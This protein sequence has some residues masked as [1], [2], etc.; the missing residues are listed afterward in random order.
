MD[1]LYLVGPNSKCDYFDLKCSLRSIDMYG[2]NVDRVFVCGYCPEFLS[3]EVIKLPLSV[4]KSLPKNKNIWRQIVHCVKNSD[5]GVYN[6]GD[7]LI[8]MDDHFYMNEVDFNKYPVLAKLSGEVHGGMLPQ[9]PNPKRETHKGYEKILIHTNKFCADHKLP[10]VFLTLH[11]NMRLNKYSIEQLDDLNNEMF[12]YKDSDLECVVI[13]QNYRLLNNPFRITFAKD[14][15]S[16]NAQSVEKMLKAN[17]RT[18]FSTGDFEIGDD[19]YN[20]L[21][22][23]YPNPSKYEKVDIY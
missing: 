6:D 8:S 1:I 5:I 14:F 3:N 9:T 16:S 7:F 12:N 23:K 19:M 10:A 4:D 15:K 20:I 2:K 11:A 13:A 18:V 21:K 17:K 22:E